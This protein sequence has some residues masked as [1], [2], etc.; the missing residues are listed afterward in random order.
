[1]RLQEKQ[2]MIAI[3]I[4]EAETQ[5]SELVEKVERSGESVL[6]LRLGRAVARIVSVAPAV[7]DVSPDP[8]LAPVEIKGDLFGD[9]SADWESA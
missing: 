3:P 5:L 4:P 9:D 8:A 7:R 6:L 2:N 1:M